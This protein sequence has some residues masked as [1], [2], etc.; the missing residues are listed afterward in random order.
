MVRR[1]RAGATPT[2]KLWNPATGVLLQTLSG[3]SSPVLSVAWSP[4]GGTLACGSGDRTVR[5]WDAASG[6]LL[7]TLTGHLDA[8]RS[9]A[10]SAD[11]KTLAS[12]SGDSTIRLWDAASGRPLRTLSGHSG[13]VRSVVWRADGSILASGSDDNTIRL[14]DPSGGTLL[15]TLTGHSSPVLAMAWSEDGTTLASGSADAVIL[16][17]DSASGRLLRTLTG[18]VVSIRSL[19]WNGDGTML[20]SGSNDSTIAVWDATSGQL[21]RKL[22]GH[23]PRCRPWRGM[24][25][26]GPSPAQ[27]RTIRLRCGPRTRHTV[28]DFAL[29][30]QVLSVAWSPVAPAL[31]AALP[32]GIDVLH[33][34][35]GAPPLSIAQFDTGEWLAHKQG[36]LLYLASPRG[37]E[38]AAIRFDHRLEAIYPLERYRSE[39][40]EDASTS[41]IPIHPSLPSVRSSRTIS[42]ARSAKIDPGCLAFRSRRVLLAF[43][44]TRFMS[45]GL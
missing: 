24:R 43:A 3:H 41:R 14:W 39:L 7:R 1:S 44:S 12:G 9:V 15:R 36:H 5:L 16:L 13:S 45:P 35:A 4:D 27:V 11:G 21:L 26:A 6:R 30:E 20:A 2:V 37:D 34:G 33:T 28:S 19:A 29:G 22:S 40:K 32:S 18:H 17:W 8:V 25:T 38:H 23:S 31:A 42:P 10:W